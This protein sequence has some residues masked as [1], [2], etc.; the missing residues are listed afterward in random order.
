MIFLGMIRKKKKKITQVSN[1]QSLDDK[2]DI[3]MNEFGTLKKDEKLFWWL[4]SS[5][6]EKIVIRI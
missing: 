5:P 2:F 3:L 6:N 1:L 4:L